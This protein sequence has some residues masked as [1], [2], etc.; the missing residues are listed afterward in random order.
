ML[1]SKNGS[2]GGELIVDSD[3]SGTDSD[4]GTEAKWGPDKFVCEMVSGKDDL[5]G[6]EV[7]SPILSLVIVGGKGKVS[8]E[9]WG[10]KRTQAVQ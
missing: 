5:S 3:S 1:F 2:G 10:G 8:G 6:V 7:I 9:G 4:G